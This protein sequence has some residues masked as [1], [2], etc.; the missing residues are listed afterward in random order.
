MYFPI[1]DIHCNPFIPPLAAFVVSF[2]TSMGGISGAFLLL[3]FQMS[4]L[5]YVNPSVSATNQFFNVVATPSGVWRFAREGRMVWPLAAVVAMGTMP[6]VF[7]GALIRVNFLPDPTTFK[8]FVA[9]VLLYIGGRML[10][11]MLLQR[12]PAPA[13]LYSSSVNSAGHTIFSLNKPQGKATARA[14]PQV[15]LVRRNWHEIAY[16]F[17]GQEYSFNTRGVFALTFIVGIIGGVYGIGGGAIISPFLVS[18]FALPIHTVAGAALL[19]TFLTSSTAVIFYMLIAPFYPTMNISPDFA[20]GLLL[21]LGGM[22]GM[23]CGA[24][25]QKYVP[26]RFIKLLLLL[27]LL[28]TAWRY[29]SSSL[30]ALLR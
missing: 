19:A 11:D 26:A 17:D 4:F 23:Y 20:L 9:C 7:F 5:G 29:G 15:R 12:R 1:A 10:R 6:G 22:A 13:P 21:G 8:L 14:F 25:C 27:V 30:L 28:G 16:S 18:F 3:P 24:R 2:F